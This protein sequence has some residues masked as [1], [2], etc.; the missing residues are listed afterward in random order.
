MFNTDVM[1]YMCTGASPAV[2]NT[3]LVYTNYYLI[4]IILIIIIIQVILR[5]QFKVSLDLFV[6]LRCF[7]VFC[8]RHV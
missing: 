7:G 6:S 4:I 3:L 2:G 1:S 8:S 5:D